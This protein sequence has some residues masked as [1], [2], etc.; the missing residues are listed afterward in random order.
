MKTSSALSSFQQCATSLYHILEGKTSWGEYTLCG[1]V[2]NWRDLVMGFGTTLAVAGFAMSY[3]RNM[4]VYCLGSFVLGVVTLFGG[5]YVKKFPT[6]LA[7]NQLVP[8]LQ[9][10]NRELKDTSQKL[11]QETGNLRQENHELRQTREALKK[12]ETN[13]KVQVQEFSQRNNELAAQVALMQAAGKKFE[14]QLLAFGQENLAFRN[15]LD[16]LDKRNETFHARF[17]KD[18]N[19][20]EGQISLQKSLNQEIFTHLAAQKDGLSTQLRELNQLLADLK[21]KEFYSQQMAIIANLKA[22]M[23]KLKQQSDEL[24]I[25]L[26]TKTTQLSLEEQ[27]LTRVRKELEETNE[28]LARNVEKL[29]QTRSQID[30]SVLQLK[31]QVDRRTQINESPVKMTLQPEPMGDSS[32]VGTHLHQ[33]SL[34]IVQVN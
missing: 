27:K 31:E 7:F 26:A 13:L 30:V 15:S 19:A 22:Q 17:D 24:D 8:S 25:A 12:I 28:K 9:K 4:P 20:L 23:E 29:E 21:N 2:F 1:R 34:Q 5:Y 16:G 32:H 3:F 11:S 10:T 33:N 6:L 14:E 18:F